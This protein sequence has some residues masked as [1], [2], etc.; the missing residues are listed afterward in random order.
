[1]AVDYVSAINTKGSGLNI[2]QIVDSLVEAE[3]KPK[4][5]LIDEKI[6]GKNLD[7]SSIGKL[8]SEINTLQ[9]SLT[10]LS[11]ISKFKTSSG[12][13][14][15]TLT[16]TDVSKAKVFSSDINISALAT[17][18]TLEF[19][20]F[21]LPT[22]S[23]G[24][25]TITI[26]FGNWIASDGTATD[27]DS[28]F[29]AGTNV[30]ANTSLGTPTTHGTL[31]GLVT[32]ATSAGGNQSST[33]FTIVGKDMAGNAVTE[34]VTG[35][36]DGATVSSSN[37]YKS[38]TSITPGSTVGSGTVT[39]GHSAST[40]GKNT[41]K[42]SSTVTISQGSSSVATIASSLNAVTGVTA[43]VINKG[44]GTYSLVVRSDLGRNSAIRMTVSENA[45]DTGL[46]TLNT[47]S[48]NANHQ[49]SAAA[50]A[51][52]TVDGVSLTR[53]SNSIT[54]I[55]DGYT[56]GLS[57]TT[58]AAFRVSSSLDETS[59]LTS[60]KTFVESFNKTR[61]IIEDLTK[62]SDNPDDNGPL[63]D[64]ITIKNIKNQLNKLVNS[65]L[66]G[67]GSKNYYASQLGLQTGRDGNLSLN[68]TKFKTNFSSDSTT[69]DAIFNSSY[70]TNSSYLT[71][72]SNSTIKPVPGTYS[73]I[74]DSDNASATLGGV[75]MTSGTDDDGNTYYAS[76][77][78]DATGIR[79]TPS[80]TVDSAFVYYGESLV[81]KLTTY[82]K[83]VLAVSGDLAKKKIEF[84]QEITEFDIELDEL[85][86][87]SETLEKRYKKQFTAME[88]AISSLKNTG[89]FMTNLMD[90][91]NKD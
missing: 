26:D 57:A 18:Q 37:V 91:F 60:M 4:K 40:F 71:V 50:D 14:N 86:G 52:L 45:S 32:I 39:V 85:D 5:D 83:Q 13:T 16:A 29:S 80:Q 43:N 2:T 77:T 64:D 54:D 88:T 8:T 55:F 81:D 62:I 87:L 28:L 27:T 17:A 68:E 31:G 22:T 67:F 65:K 21:T 36:G 51:T 59:A 30:T 48:D 3:T 6:E 53:S 12:N 1:M 79:V 89:E 70:S 78:G 49:T 46:S 44:D 41:A 90:S 74:Y 15:T 9:T 72:A 25:G 11:N 20:G 24:S 23:V 75:T 61:V 82:T 58:T 19:S 84:N 35:G 76:T 63:S 42:T 38:V 56:L 66:T 47:T 10:A 7:I 34:V 69:F 73:F 33:S